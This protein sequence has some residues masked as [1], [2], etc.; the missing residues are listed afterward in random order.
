MKE[1]KSEKKYEMIFCIVNAGFSETVM[2]AAK[3]AGA[4]GGT[5]VRARGT[6]NQDAEKL[7]EITVH[8][9]KEIVMI[10]VPTEIK[11]AVLAAV[12]AVATS[13]DVRGIAFSL[14]VSRTL[15]LE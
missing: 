11:D 15:G 12:Y 2:E 3:A 13:G 1:T 6:A 7:F 14:A 5:I 10:L 9:D 4:R 8:S